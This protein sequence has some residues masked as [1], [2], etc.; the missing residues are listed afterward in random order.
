M[1]FARR[2]AGG[3]EVQKNTLQN[4]IKIANCLKQ[5]EDG[6]L[7]PTEI[8]K[9]TGIHRTTVIRLIERH[10]P[11]FVEEQK[12][13]PS[14]IRMFKLKPDASMTAVLKFLS[15]RERISRAVGGRG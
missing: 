14:N 3:L 13:E 12:L 9:R 8:A 1:Y 10:L 4:V 7:W 15:V 2:R 5:A 11:N 6:W